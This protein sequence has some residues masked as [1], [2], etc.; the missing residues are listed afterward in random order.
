MYFE[1]MKMLDVPK[2]NIESEESEERWISKLLRRL[3][4]K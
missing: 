2:K 1:F 3:L 4:K